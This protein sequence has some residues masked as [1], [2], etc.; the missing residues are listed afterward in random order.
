[1]GEPMTAVRLKIYAADLADLSPS[2]LQTAFT[3]ARRESQFFPKIAQLREL[4][5]EASKQRQDAECRKAWD[6]LQ[7]FV[8]RYVGNDVFDNYGPEH[9]WYPKTFPHLSDRIVD[10]VRRS[11]GWKTYKC[12]T[13]EDFPFVQKRF[14]DEYNAW[15]AIERVDAGHMLTAAV[16]QVKQLA[17]AKT[18]HRQQPSRPT[19][20]PKPI[21]LPMTDAQFRDRREMLRQQAEM[22]T[23]KA[24]VK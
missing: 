22:L 21:P 23:K 20:I 7:T 6:T 16:L 14:F 3:R 9:G 12:M 24:T 19:F 8:R 10:S 1:M 15:T 4:A 2:Q 18:E 13:D 5:G 11:G 17:A